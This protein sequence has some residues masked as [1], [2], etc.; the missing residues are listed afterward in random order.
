LIALALLTGPEV[1]TRKYYYADGTR[2]AMRENGELRWLFGDHLGSTAI[3]ADGSSGAKEGELRYKAYGENRYA[4]GETP[5]D[6][7][8]TGQAE[9]SSI[10]LYYYNARW[11]DASLGRFVQADT[12]V[13]APGNPQDLNRYSYVRNN[14]LGYQ[15]PSGHSPSPPIGTPEPRPT[16]QSDALTVTPQP[17]PGLVGTPSPSSYSYSRFWGGMSES[18]LAK[19]EQDQLDTNYCHSYSVATA[20][21]MLTGS[22]LTGSSV[23][24]MANIGFWLFQGT[25]FLPGSGGPPKNQVAQVEM[26]NWIAEI[27]GMSPGLSAEAMHGTTDDLIAILGQSD[28]AAIV[29]IQKRKGDPRSAHAMVLAAYDPQKTDKYGTVKPWGFINSA[30]GLQAPELFWMT[31]ADF[32]EQWGN[33]GKLW[34]IDVTFALGGNN[35]MVVIDAP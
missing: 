19:L 20:I 4:W 8:F 11:Y 3:T 24:H 23:A 7:R 30:D 26:L 33:W 28:K 12:I 32:R 15:D 29:T 22:K 1:T 18:D 21:N 31:D 9:H 13:P 27:N 34:R 16:P 35:N 25:I 6:Y 14:P 2:V 10:G 5:T 17:Y